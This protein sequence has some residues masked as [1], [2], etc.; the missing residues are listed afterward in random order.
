MMSSET[1]DVRK[2][3][4]KRLSANFSEA[5]AGS[6][7]GDRL[8]FHSS[9]ELSER[10]NSYTMSAFSSQ[11]HSP[12][13]RSVP[14]QEC[15]GKTNAIF[16]ALTWKITPD[17]ERDLLEPQFLLGN[18]QRVRLPFQLDEYGGVHTSDDDSNH[19]KYIGNRRRTEQTRANVEIFG[20]AR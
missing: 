5:K 17:H 15:R 2:V 11:S 3:H 9:Y 6:D 14:E 18:L 19:P 13:E 1:C 10:A 7:D 4:S 16:P 20:S 8:T 12:S